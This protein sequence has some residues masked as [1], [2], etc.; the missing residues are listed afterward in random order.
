MKYEYRVRRLNWLD[1]REYAQVYGDFIT[2]GAFDSATV[3]E[4]KGA[5]WVVAERVKELG[6]GRAVGVNARAKP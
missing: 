6:A 2:W 4:D 5:A 3:Y 1:E